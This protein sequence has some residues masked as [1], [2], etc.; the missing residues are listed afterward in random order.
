MRGDKIVS[1]ARLKL[2]IVPHVS[3]GPNMADIGNTHTCIHGYYLFEEQD[4]NR[5]K[6][7]ILQLNL[8]KELVARTGN[9]Q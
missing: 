5:K 6:D 2:C 8:M 3:V 4:V 1:H 9:N 7:S